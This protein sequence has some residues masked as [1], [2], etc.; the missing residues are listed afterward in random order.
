MRFVVRVDPR[1]HLRAHRSRHF[2]HPI[3][4]LREKRPMRR[5]EQFGR[6]RMRSLGKLGKTYFRL[7]AV[8]RRDLLGD[9]AVNLERNIAGFGVPNPQIEHRGLAPVAEHQP[10]VIRVKHEDR[11]RRRLVPVECQIT[12]PGDAGGLGVRF[13]PEQ[14]RF[15]FRHD[16]VLCFDRR[17]RGRSLEQLRGARAEKVD[18][19]PV[20]PLRRLNSKRADI[21]LYR[22]AAG[23]NS[24]VVVGDGVEFRALRRIV[25]LQ[26]AICHAEAFRIRIPALQTLGE[27]S[28]Y[29]EV[30]A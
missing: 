13:D 8:A 5:V 14:Q 28:I 1:L 30:R 23:R 19:D 16:D 6:N 10:P 9:L 12:E 20:N 17:P 22:V 2:H 24:V 27:I 7:H 25:Q 18:S 21:A 11:K 15:A 26:R 29:Q 4:R 3:R